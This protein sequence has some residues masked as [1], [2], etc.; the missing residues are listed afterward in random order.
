VAEG[1]ELSLF[2]EGRESAPTHLTLEW[3]PVDGEASRHTER[4]LSDVREIGA[5]VFESKDR[6]WA[7]TEA[8]GRDDTGLSFSWHG[9]IGSG[10]DIEFRVPR[11]AELKSQLEALGYAN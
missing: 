2:L 8:L 1:Q 5:L 11:S 9:Q 3:I 6:T 4:E 7:E 10:R